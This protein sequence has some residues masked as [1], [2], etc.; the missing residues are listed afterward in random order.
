MS[1]PRSLLFVLC[2]VAAASAPLQAQSVAPQRRL[3]GGGNADPTPPTYSSWESASDGVSTA[4]DK[5]NVAKQKAYDAKRKYD[6]LRMSGG[7][8]PDK[9]GQIDELERAKDDAERTANSFK[10][11]FQRAVRGASTFVDAEAKA[12]S[13]D[14]AKATAKQHQDTVRG[15][16]S[17]AG[18]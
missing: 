8:S 5:Y 9:R 17:E 7:G 1:T 6:D 2:L 15:W 14:A 3:P 12:A 18:M 4:R 10:G 11:A 16:K 13:T